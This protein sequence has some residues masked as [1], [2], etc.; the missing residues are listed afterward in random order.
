MVAACPPEPIDD[1]GTTA[2]TVQDQQVD[3]S[4]GGQAL[5]AGKV[6]RVVDLGTRLSPGRAMQSLEVSTSL[7][8]RPQGTRNG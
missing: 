5:V 1:E 8:N 2:H 7:P 4:E 6:G 3:V